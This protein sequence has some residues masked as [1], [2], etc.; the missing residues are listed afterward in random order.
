MEELIHVMKPAR[1]SRVEEEEKGANR[2]DS[3]SI[4]VEAS[5]GV[6]D[7]GPPP[8]LQRQFATRDLMRSPTPA[9]NIQQ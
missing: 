9:S 2:A 7:M 8:L 4:R 3:N 6:K 5:R 1:L